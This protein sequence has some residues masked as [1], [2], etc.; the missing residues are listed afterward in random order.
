MTSACQLEIDLFRRDLDT[1][2]LEKLWHHDVEFFCQLLDR[3]CFSRQT[4]N[5]FTG[6]DPDGGLGVPF[7]MNVVSH[8]R[9]F[10][11]SLSFG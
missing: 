8:S 6:R 5:V 11:E 9:I 10:A 2:G 7:R 4:R 1:V 3:R